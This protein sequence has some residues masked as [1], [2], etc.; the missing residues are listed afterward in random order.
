LSKVI[1]HLPYSERA[2][3]DSVTTMEKDGV[4]PAGWEEGYQ[5]WKPAFDAGK[6]GVWTITV[7]EA[8]SAME[9]ILGKQ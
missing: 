9:Q 2:L 7:S 5:Q 1:S 8:V 4:A 6:A 3:A